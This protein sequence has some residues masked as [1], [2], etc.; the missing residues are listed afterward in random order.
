MI[1]QRDIIK[2]LD[3]FKEKL[4]RRTEITLF[5]PG[6]KIKILSDVFSNEL[7]NLY[8]TNKQSFESINISTSSGKD[9]QA[10]G[11]SKGVTPFYETYAQVSKEELCL[12]WYVSSGTFGNLNDGNDIVIP[13]GTEIW[14]NPK[15]NDMGRK[16]TYKTTEQITLSAASSVAYASAKAT[17]S[18]SASN[19]GPGVLKNHNFTDYESK[20]GLRIINFNSILNGNDRENEELY[21][22]R[23]MQ[24]YSGKALNNSL[25]YSIN[26]LT[27]PG[28]LDTKIIENYY[29]LG[30]V[31]VVVL[32]TEY[33]VNNSMLNDVQLYF[34]NNF[35]ASKKV[36]AVAPV[37]AL[38]KFKLA[39]TSSK[40]LTSTEQ[41]NI[42][43][44]Y[45]SLAR[46]YLRSQGLGGV[47]D[48]EKMAEIF[49][50][51]NT[52]GLTTK[53]SNVT[54]FDN[55]TVNRNIATALHSSEE[56]LLKTSY[57]LEED[58]YADIDDIE[59]VYG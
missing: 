46:E 32:G 30:T 50:K 10:L 40:E 11:L 37:T 43:N 57:A 49:I 5:D 14:T 39:V 27:I 51:R 35:L 28:V 56:N 3:S 20:T 41:N 54:I 59:I 26:A 34:N 15:Q 12:A 4:T 45:I 53:K 55:V 25:S 24:S 33:Q 23:V 6:S 8:Q 21:R 48:L 22:Y 31:G 13:T 16:I 58:E 42:K 2:Y 1:D 7:Y 44:F 36:Y 47:I 29:G 18:G 19:V 9:L 38:F 52:F 17:A